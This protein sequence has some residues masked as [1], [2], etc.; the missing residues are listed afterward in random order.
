MGSKQ[1]LLPWIMGHL[2]RLSYKTALDAFSG[3][4]CVSHAMKTH[5]VRVIANDMLQFAYHTAKATIENN[6]IQLTSEDLKILLKRNRKAPTFI[7]DTFR[8]LY[9]VDED[10]LFLDETRANID[11]L[12]CEYKH[13]LALAALCRACMK[14]RPRGIFTFTGRKGWDG[15]RDLAMTMSEQFVRAVAEINDAVVSNG[16]RNKALC[17]DVFNVP[18]RSL[19]LVY[20][21]TPYISLHSDCDYTRRYH[22]VE[23]L[24]LYWSGVDI[25]MHTSTRKIT[26]YP[27][28]FRSV[29]TAEMAFSKLFEH[30]A[31]VPTIV[32]SY[33][34][35][36]I[37]TREN[38][39]G[40]LHGIKQH[41]KVHESPHRYSFGNQGHCVGRNNN[42]VIEYLYVAQ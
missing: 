31:K 24:C 10:N 13:S 12:D 33:S 5:G 2:N 8:D 27:T 15:R 40:L 26:S 11:R 7:Q 42:N 17:L 34:S 29:K 36:G 1:A 18:T 16:R 41:V 35:N 28:A 22:F 14:K 9:F 37:P 39:V 30:F 6:H 21:D 32:V 23:G 4:A 38:M 19:D 3:S 25:Q 20:I